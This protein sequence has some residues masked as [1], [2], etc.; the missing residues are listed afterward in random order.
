M[1]VSLSA[2]ASTDYELLN[3]S[4]ILSSDYSS[5]KS[6]DTV[7][8]GEF[9]KV[10]SEL[11]NLENALVDYS[12]LYN[13]V[14]EETKNYKEIL[15]LSEMKILSGYADGS[16]RSEKEVLY[17]EAIKV[18]VNLLGYDYKAKAYGGYPAGYLMA[19][20]ELKLLSGAE[21]SFTAPITFGLLMKILNNA[22]NTPI[23]EINGVDDSGNYIYKTDY[24]NTLGYKYHNIRKAKGNITA[25]PYA[26]LEGYFKAIDG[27]INIDGTNYYTEDFSLISKI[28]MNVEFVYRTDKETDKKTLIYLKETENNKITEIDIKDYVSYSSNTIYYTDKD[29][30]NKSI[31]ISPLSDVIVNSENKGISKSLLDSVK[32]G[33]IKIIKS[34]SADRNDVVI[35]SS[36]KDMIVGKIDEFNK[37]LLSENGSE[38]LNLG[39]NN[40]DIRV[41]DKNGNQ[42]TFNFISSGDI[43]TYA[44]GTLYAEIYVSGESVNGVI[45]DIISENNGSFIV[46]SENTYTIS[47]D[48]ENIVSSL[49][50][51]QNVRLSLNKFGLASKIKVL[52]EDGF[53]FLYMLKV[54]AVNQ[55][56]P[57]ESAVAKFFSVDKGVVTYDIA[58]NVK[59]GD[60]YIK[61]TNKLKIETAL[62]GQIDR[63]VGIKLSE[64]NKITHILPAKELSELEAAGKDGFVRTHPVAERHLYENPIRFDLS[65]QLA[66]ST[67]ILVIPDDV[68]LADDDDYY[69]TVA[70]ALPEG[71]ELKTEAYNSTV[72]YGIPDFVIYRPSAGTAAAPALVYESPL[73]I[74][75]SITKVRTEDGAPATKI[76]VQNGTS[77]EYF[78]YDGSEI[79]DN[80]SESLTAYKVSEIGV[81][82]IIR[83][84]PDND[85]FIRIVEVYYDASK[86]LWMYNSNNITRGRGFIRD[87][88]A[89]VVGD[90]LYVPAWK[91]HHEGDMYS[92]VNLTEKTLSIGG[93]SVMTLRPG[94]DPLISPGTTAD[95]KKQDN[96]I[97]H[98]AY[99]Q[100]IGII[101]IK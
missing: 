12:S 6:E 69:M 73:V 53:E 30:K 61:E 26:A 27:C 67:P 59:V 54:G 42:V 11:M 49:K 99:G 46:I 2:F 50:I 41:L 65:I 96:V 75:K 48:I 82:D 1:L 89:K 36:Y 66:N 91:G 101:V 97:I 29:G 5:Y 47:P 40:K 94:K 80:T 64:D 3:S 16:F 86:D 20:K 43:L 34:E 87:N 52:S 22:V 62:N 9:A 76:T 35:I 38:I 18:L 37:K 28:G 39:D 81:G 55:G 83:Y 93:I 23:A 98:V 70:S 72:D 92:G 84:S 8:R 7:T 10:I 63:M 45:T 56:T 21:D 31:S 51:G 60:A 85:N 14:T 19:A 77:E 74:V 95:I 79:S 17:S 100:L 88:V 57:T 78:Y 33:S 24:S 25:T 90:F 71:K 32:M 13:D 58:T 4:G 15:T 44:D 68:S